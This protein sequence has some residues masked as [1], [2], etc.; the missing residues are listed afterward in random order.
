MTLDNAILI[1]DDDQAIRT[2]LTQALTRVGMDVRS[3]GN[4]ATL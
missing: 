3:P 2:V 4:A 1:A